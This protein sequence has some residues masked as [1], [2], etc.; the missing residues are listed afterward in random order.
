MF[1]EAGFGISLLS[2]THPSG[3]RS[4]GCDPGW[5]QDVDEA[6]AIDQSVIPGLNG[7]NSSTGNRYY[8]AGFSAAAFLPVMRPMTR[9]RVMEAPLPG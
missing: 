4:D 5:R 3:E 8:F 6:H 2:R 7:L 9:P 1:G